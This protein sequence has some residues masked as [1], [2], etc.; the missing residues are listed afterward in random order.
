[1]VILRAALRAQTEQT[2][3][4]QLAPAEEPEKKD[5]KNHGQGGK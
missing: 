1:M 3:A 2:L 5:K 4:R